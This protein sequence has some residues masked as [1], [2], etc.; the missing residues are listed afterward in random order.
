MIE[1]CDEVSAK[2][3]KIDQILY[4]IKILTILNKHIIY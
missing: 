1:I 4:L 2:F 3:K